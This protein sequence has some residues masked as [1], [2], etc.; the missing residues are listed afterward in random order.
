[1]AELNADIAPQVLAASQENAEEAAG[2]IGRAFEGEYTL[3]PA[4]AAAF[5]AGAESHSGAGMA[6]L[7]KYGDGPG[8][9]VVLSAS[10]GLVPDWVKQPDATGA[11]KLSTLA[12]EL[13]M[14]LMPEDL[15]ADDFQ[16]A[17]VDDLSAA[18]GNAKPGEGALALPV[19]LSSGESLGMLSLV[20]PLEQPSALL[21]GDA[22]AEAPAEEPEQAAEEAEQEAP[23]E[24]AEQGPE[25]GSKEEKLARVRRW[26]GPPPRDF[27]DLP[28]NTRSMLQVEVPVSVN[29]AGK[30]MRINEIVEIGP[31][32][33]I[34]F[35][36]ACDDELEITVGN[37]PIAQGEA[38]KVGEKFGVRVQ[39]MILPNEHFRPM[40]PPMAG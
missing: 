35:D 3:K 33:I 2:A 38:V 21:E 27:K 8:A 22:P 4:E 12:Q 28:P 13:S 23:A 34:T 18:L 5:E 16:A 14:L 17:W 9:A 26:I 25:P 19:E 20:W 29:L 39:K 24:P 37:L 7:F 11:S 36:K 15:M 32:A 6:V 10:S 40:L 31:G 1:M 30:K